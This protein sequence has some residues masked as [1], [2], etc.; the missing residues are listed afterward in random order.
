MREREYRS[1][2]SGLVLACVCG[3]GAHLHVEDFIWALGLA[4]DVAHFI[5][6]LRWQRGWRVA[7]GCWV[8][9]RTKGMNS[10]ITNTHYA[11]FSQAFVQPIRGLKEMFT[12]VAPPLEP[13]PLDS[14]CW[15]R[16]F[17]R[18]E[19]FRWWSGSGWHACMTGI[20]SERINKN[21]SIQVYLRTALFQSSFTRESK[22]KTCSQ[23]KIQKIES[24]WKSSGVYLYAQARLHE[25]KLIHQFL[26]QGSHVLR[27]EFLMHGQ[28][29]LKNMSLQMITNCI[30]YAA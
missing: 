21:E 6:R 5:G 24:Y 16:S 29:K 3:P 18:H 1:K 11:S 13:L 30:D 14:R 4:R 17:F 19:G 7:I 27:N 12:C 22:N 10:T 28:T 2:K 20:P 26:V 25:V 23:K 9:E 8:A 15:V